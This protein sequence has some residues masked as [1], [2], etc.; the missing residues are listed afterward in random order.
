MYGILLSRSE[1]KHLN[2]RKEII[3]EI[4]R[5]DTANI[6]EDAFYEAARRLYDDYGL[7]FGKT[8]V[9]EYV[10]EAALNDPFVDSWVDSL[11]PEQ[12]KYIVSYMRAV[13]TDYMNE[14]TNDQWDAIMEEK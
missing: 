1:G 9:L 13:F 10:I 7:E 2:T 6:T 14:I 8:Q 12:T 4:K 3:M 11:T 5:T